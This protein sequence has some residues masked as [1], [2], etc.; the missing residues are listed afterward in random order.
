DEQHEVGL[1]IPVGGWTV[2]LS[3]F[4]TG[5]HNFFDHDALGNSNIFVP[6]TI[7]SVRTLGYEATPRSPKLP[8]RAGLHLAYSHQSVEADGGVTGGFTDFSAPDSGFF[9]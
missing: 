8:K 9:F 6:L 1:T 5:A 2:D 4:R 7:D 3:H